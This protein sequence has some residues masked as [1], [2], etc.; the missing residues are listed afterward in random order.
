MGSGGGGLAADTL[1]QGG[2]EPIDLAAG[3][4][5]VDVFQLGGQPAG[6]DLIKRV[7]MAQEPLVKG[8]G[9]LCE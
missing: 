6:V 2:A 1:E 7:G 9:C 8:F 5:G 4:G 3:S